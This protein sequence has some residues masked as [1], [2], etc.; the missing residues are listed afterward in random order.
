MSADLRNSKDA[1]RAV[2]E[3]VKWNG[4]LDP[5][6]VWCCAGQSLPGFFVNTSPETLKDQMDTVYWTAAFTAH[7][8][9]R[10]WFSPVPPGQAHKVLSPRHLVFTSSAA[11]FVPITGYAPYTPAKTAMRGLA[12]TLVQEAEV[13]NGART[14]KRNHAPPADVKIH[15]IFPMGILS[16]GFAHEQEMKPELT[17][18][19]EEA[20]KPQTPDEVAQISINRLEKG[21][22]MITTM[23]VGT[24][25]K[26]S[27]MGGSPR[28]GCI[29]DTL[30]SWVSSIAFLQV[31][32]DLTRKARKWGRTY[33]VPRAN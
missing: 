25:M 16:P 22:Y 17:K 3:I 1:D 14:N 31:I 30:T 6:I 33:G 18:Q 20:D 10:R 12:D 27:A 19:L 5:D 9:L 26:G 15:I 28:N 8:T 7:A 13:Y 4:G 21:E 11:A 29:R 24:I 2:K 23:L 32:P